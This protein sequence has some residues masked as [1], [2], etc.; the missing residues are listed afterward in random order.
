MRPR[1][2]QRA[3]NVRYYAANREREIERVTRR[4]AATT[5]FLRELRSVPCA[6]C[7][8]RFEGHQ[9]D[10][11]QRDPAAKI[12]GGTRMISRS[13]VERILAEVDKCDIVCANCHRLRTH[14]RRSRAA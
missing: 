6:D 14:E 4:Q 12:Q 1:P 8:A 7:G 11:D 5:A 9:M 2:T 13:S 3:T 10:F